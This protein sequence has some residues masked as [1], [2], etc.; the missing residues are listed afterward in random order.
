MQ[1]LHPNT[2]RCVRLDVARLLIVVNLEKPLPNKINITGLD[3]VIQVSYPWLPS[4]CSICHEWGHD[5]KGCDKMQ[6]GAAEETKVTTVP[7]VAVVHPVNDVMTKVVEDD[8]ATCSLVTKNGRPS[9][10]RP[11]SPRAKLH[12]VSDVSHFHVLSDVCEEGEF[13]PANLDEAVSEPTGK[14]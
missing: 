9:P 3:T 11:E 5:G 1:R 2:E 10:L 12:D 4:R 6:K 14:P 8:E 7:N 13:V